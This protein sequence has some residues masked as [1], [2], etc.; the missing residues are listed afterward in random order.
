MA[1]V[2]SEGGG[3][4]CVCM[5]LRGMQSVHCVLMQSKFSMQ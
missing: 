1:Q 2:K 4:T 3:G 5:C